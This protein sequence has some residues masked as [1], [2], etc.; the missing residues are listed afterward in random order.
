MPEYVFKCSDD[1]C[2]AGFF[3]TLAIVNRN[4]PF[5]VMVVEKIRLCCSPFTSFHLKLFCCEN[6]ILFPITGSWWLI[7][8][9]PGLLLPCTW[10]FTI[11]E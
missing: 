3:K 2:G 1:E 9:F 11:I 10:P 5:Q 7:L 4:A 8:K 6:T